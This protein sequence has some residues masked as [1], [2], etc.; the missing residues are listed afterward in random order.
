M[1]LLVAAVIVHDVV[2]GR[3]ILIQRGPKAKFA[4]GRW[5]LPIGK[6][7]PGEPVT[8]TA[9]RELK[10]ETGL[11]VT[12]DDLEVA[13]VI[14]GSQGVESPSGFLTVVF[15]ATRW[16]GE[17]VNMEPDKHSAVEWADVVELPSRAF[18]SDRLDALTAYLT[19]TTSITCSG[20]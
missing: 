6:N 13:H 20:W 17:P 7:A 3:I 12:P 14:H 16:S 2:N 4:R 5:D 19:G 8:M 10:E 18:V 15:A 11:I 1:T 9:V